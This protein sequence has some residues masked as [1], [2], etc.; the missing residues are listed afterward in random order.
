MDQVKTILCEF[1][2]S[3]FEIDIYLAVL[4]LGPA[5]IIDVAKKIGKN[6]TAVYFHIKNLLQKGILK[7]ARKGKRVRFVAMPPAE[8][9][10]HFSKITT[11]FRSLVPQLESLFRVEKEVPLIEVTESAK[12]YFKVYDEIS[13]MPIGST[14]RVLEG[15]KALIAEFALLTEEEWRIFFT[16]TAERKIETRGIFT[17]E[18]L[19][20]P[21]QALS[22]DNF[23][24]IGERIWHLRTLPEEALPFQQLLFIY[25]EKIAFLF[26]DTALVVTIQHKDIATSLAAVFDGLY[27][28][29][30]I[31]PHG[32]KTDFSQE[33]F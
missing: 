6:R 19:R 24:N 23:K 32:W 21:Q 4:A 22:S 18:S 31:I 25:G 5:G 26:P 2:F 16:R 9:A 14:F 30:Q 17:K 28:F 10:D 8:M 33:L 13:S 12:G 11:D 3:E 20:V 7:E 29:A 1:A 27:S 15:K